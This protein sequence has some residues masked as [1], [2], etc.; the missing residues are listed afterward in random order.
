MKMNQKGFSLIELMAVLF[1]SSV[2]L[3][4]LLISFTDSIKINQRSQTNRIATTV[5]EGALYAF[6]KIDFID[7]RT[8]LSTENTNGNYYLEL[9]L[10]ECP[11]IFLN[12]DDLAI[13]ESI[14]NMTSSNL[15]FTSSQFKVYMFDYSLTTAEYNAL[16]ANQSIEVSVRNELNNNT[17][18][19]A[20]LNGVDTPHLIWVIIWLDYFDNPEQYLVATGLIAND[21]VS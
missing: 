6:E 10:D 8:A 20:A 4:P 18:I 19:V 7:Y 15:S 9:N 13:C 21:D 14:F 5:A 11:N 3:V 12:A 1:I 17:D 2:V 16:L